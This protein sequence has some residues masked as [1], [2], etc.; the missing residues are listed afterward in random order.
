METNESLKT[1][2]L[3]ETETGVLRM[4]KHLHRLAEGDLQ[5]VEHTVMRA[6]LAMGQRWLEEVLTHPRAENRP[7]ARR[8]GACGHQQRLVGERPKQR[9][10]WLGKVRVRGR[11]SLSA[12]D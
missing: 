3:H 1:A 11:I 5:Q 7:Q 8:E 12:S 9:L 6:C 4:W 2:L 10:P